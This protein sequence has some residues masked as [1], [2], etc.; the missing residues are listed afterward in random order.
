[1]IP[2]DI[3]EHT[4]ESFSSPRISSKKAREYQDSEPDDD[5]Y[6]SL[7]TTGTETSHAGYEQGDPTLNEPPELYPFSS[8]AEAVLG[9]AI[10]LDSAQMSSPTTSTHNSEWHKEKQELEAKIQKQAELI[11]MI[12]ADLQEK[13]S[14]SH[15]LQEQLAQAI[16]LAH[17]RD[18]RHE[19]MM[20]KFERLM[21]MQEIH[22][23][24]ED[25]SQL[26]SMNEPTPT[27][28][29]RPTKP[30]ASPPT[31]R[32]N[33][34]ASPNRTVYAVFRQPLGKNPGNKSSFMGNYLKNHRPTPNSPLRLMD[35]DEETLPPPPG[36]KS[37]K[38]QE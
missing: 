8:Y 10:S 13:L 4:P 21:Q 3:L 32:A 35:I 11:E 30:N 5:S 2:T 33:T 17:S 25:N 1:M 36:V 16:E 37:G 12:Q 26:S 24:Q 20:A 22:T 19:E 6:G 15:D 38:K 27:T 18:Q 28:P 14:L 31:K 9:S 34:N 29:S 23:Q 7:L